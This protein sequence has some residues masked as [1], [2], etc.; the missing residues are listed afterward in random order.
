[1]ERGFLSIHPGFS[2]IKIVKRG[3]GAF[4][5]RR[6]EIP[7]GSGKQVDGLS[8]IKGVQ[9]GWFWM[10]W[11]WDITR[12]YFASGHVTVSGMHSIWDWF[13]GPFLG[14][15]SGSSVLFPELFL[16]VWSCSLR[17]VGDMTEIWGRVSLEEKKRFSDHINFGND[18]CLLN[19]TQ[20]F[21]EKSC[22]WKTIQF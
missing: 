2:E 13:C 5:E 6:L 4:A 18:T 9:T 15:V 10:S 11:L 1:M 17:L 14:V 20:I 12:G 22:G 19:F 16:T 7:Y 8:H 21:F 3:D